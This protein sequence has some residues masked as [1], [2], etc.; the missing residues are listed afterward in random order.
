MVLTKAPKLISFTKIKP[1]SYTEL[2]SMDDCILRGLIKSRSVINGL[3]NKQVIS[4]DLISGNIFHKLMYDLSKYLALPVTSRIKAIR[5]DID[6]YIEEYSNIYD[7]FDFSDYLYWPKLERAISSVLSKASLDLSEV[8]ARE[9]RIE[10]FDAKVVGIIDLIEK[11]SKGLE[12]V[13]YKSRSISDKFD[14]PQ[15]YIHQLHFYALLIKE[16]YAE[17]PQKGYIE[18]F[19]SERC[20]VKFDYNITEELHKKAN[21]VYSKIN[22]VIKRNASTESISNLTPSICNKCSVSYLCPELET[23]ILKIEAYTSRVLVAKIESIQGCNL[24]MMAVSG[25]I[26]GGK[27][28]KLEVETSWAESIKENQ[29]YVFTDLVYLQSDKYKQSNNSIIYYK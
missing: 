14:L 29:L 12:I 18:Y 2:S 11:T 1:I 28:I 23:R 21:S 26:C 25:I 9:K 24:E 22:D 10:S 19:D 6:L 27:K 20:S 17:Y 3:K 5:N 8:I 16:E 15:T 7:N 4:K 13:D